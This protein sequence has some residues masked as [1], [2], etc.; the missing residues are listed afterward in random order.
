M[1]NFTTLGR[2]LSNAEQK[3]VFGGL[4]ELVKICTCENT[5]IQ[6]LCRDPFSVCVSAR[7]NGCGASA[8]CH[9]GGVTGVE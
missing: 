7:N 2:G 3:D 9:V 1:I 6:F 4:D 8:V 5:G